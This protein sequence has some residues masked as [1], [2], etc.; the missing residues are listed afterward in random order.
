VAPPC[1]IGVDVGGT[2]VLAGA[3]DETLG[4][5]HRSRRVVAGSADGPAVLATVLAAIAD[6]RDAVDGDV[7][8]VGVGIPSLI[9]RRTGV[10]VT[11]VH[12]PIR[13]VPAR[14]I[15]AERLGIPVAVDNDGNCAALAEARHGAGRGA[16]RMLMITL[17]TGIGGA[18]VFGGELDRGAL[19][20]AGEF[21]HMVVDR[22]GPPCHGNCHNRGCLETVASGT[23]LA[24]AAV[25]LAAERPESGLA[26]AAQD[27]RP[28]DGMLVTELAREG[29][30]AAREAVA[31][32]GTAL[33]V[34]LANLVN[35]FNPDVVVVGG[36]V[37]ANGELLLA[38]ARREML[39]RALSPSREHVRVVAARFGAEAGMRGAG[40][41]AWDGLA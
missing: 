34:G 23:A 11:T 8:A 39:A 13:D 5:H 20:A 38:P 41:L 27:G 33:G 14:D 15:F 6:V 21:G 26:R 12:L 37:L 29:D 30:E 18:M 25:V 31:R 32:I 40:L 28:L 24:R 35:I 22:D 10:A 2:K 9:D 19:G 16:E 3:V 7:A 4:V 36:G 1:V 17:G